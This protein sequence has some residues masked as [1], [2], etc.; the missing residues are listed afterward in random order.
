MSKLRESAVTPVS[1]FWQDL[2][3]L[4]TYKSSLASL[5]RD[6]RLAFQWWLPQFRS[7][8]LLH[9]NSLG[10]TGK[11][12]RLGVRGMVR[13]DRSIFQ[14]VRLPVGP[15]QSAFIVHSATNN[16]IWKTLAM[17]VA[18]GETVRSVYTRRT[19]TH[20]CAFI[21]TLMDLLHKGKLTHVHN[22]PALS[23]KWELSLIWR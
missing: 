4:K 16:S 18:F 19:F 22:C 23:Q 17:F 8:V 21:R 14:I 5:W 15:A 12:T 11:R 13:G 9:A 1:R 6:E 2:K 3:D 20:T 7:A 10:S